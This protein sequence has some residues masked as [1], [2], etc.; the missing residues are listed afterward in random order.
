MLR[1]PVRSFPRPGRESNPAAC[2]A[3]RREGIRLDEVLKAAAEERAERRGLSSQGYLAD[4]IE[5]D[6]YQ[7]RAFMAG[8]SAFLAAYTEEGR[9]VNLRIDRA[10]ILAVAQRIPSDPPVV[11]H[12]VPVAAEAHHRAE[13]STTRSTPR[14][15]TKPRHRCANRRETP[16]WR[17]GTCSSR[18][19]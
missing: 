17:C 2:A 10:W 13:T 14:P 4:L 3:R 19:R 18:P 11:D 16:A 8:A 6:G 1:S 15:V 7:S 9:R 12:G 5:A